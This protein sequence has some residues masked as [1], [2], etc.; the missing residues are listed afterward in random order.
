MEFLLYQITTCYP[1][2]VTT[3]YVCLCVGD[4]VFPADLH[5]SDAIP[6]YGPCE[7]KLEDETITVRN[8]VTTRTPHQQQFQWSISH[9]KK[10]WV[11]SDIHQLVIMVGR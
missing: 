6:F 11:K 4:A 7:M 8:R 3:L 9:V 2:S 10:F 5:K 1:I